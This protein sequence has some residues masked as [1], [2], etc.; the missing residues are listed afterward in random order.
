[1][2]RDGRTGISI[3]VLH[4]LEEIEEQAGSC[5]VHVEIGV[6]M[7]WTLSQLATEDQ[8]AD[9]MSGL[10]QAVRI[11]SSYLWPQFP[12]S[13]INSTCRCEAAAADGTAWLEH[14]LDFYLPERQQEG[15]GSAVHQLLCL[16]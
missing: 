4:S 10:P 11:G 7:V 16:F 12:Q 2:D 6:K 9:Q 5:Q 3:Y 13:S 14:V 1:V 15:F 8:A